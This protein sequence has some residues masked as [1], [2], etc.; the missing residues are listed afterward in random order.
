MLI[1]SLLYLTGCEKLAL[2]GIRTFRELGSHCKRHPEVDPSTGFEI[3]AGL[4][5]QGIANAAGMAVA[6][7][8]PGRQPGGRKPTRDAARSPGAG[9]RRR[10]LQLMAGLQ[11]RQLGLSALV[12]EPSLRQLID[13]LVEQAKFP[14]T[15]AYPLLELRVDIPHGPD[16]RKLLGSLSPRLLVRLLL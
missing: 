9:K 15:L 5:S 7:A 13:G 12:N 6:E 11:S 14:P 8:F 16:H 4:L 3:T 1:Y 10:F 2:D